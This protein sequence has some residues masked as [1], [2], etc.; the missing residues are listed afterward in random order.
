MAASHTIEKERN[1]SLDSQ[2]T[3]YSAAAEAELALDAGRAKRPNRPTVA[4]S[5][6]AAGA[7]LLG[8]LNADAAIQ[9]TSAN[10]TMS[11][12][13]VQTWMDIDGGGTDDIRFDFASWGA[14]RR[15]NVNGANGGEFLWVANVGVGDAV[16]FAY[17][18]TISSLAG[19]WK[20]G[21]GYIFQNSGTF[22]RGQF[23]DVNTG[24]LGVR[25]SAGGTKYGWI[26][27]DLVAAGGSSFHIAGYAYED[28]GSPIQA[29]ARI[30]EPSTIALALLASGAAGVM[31]SRRK[32]ILKGR[33]K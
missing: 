17:G 31:R 7:G 33:G 15:G 13:N 28:D 8:A 21:A 4:Y 24:Y 25:F 9:Y 14:G 29:G 10:L 12:G 2:L 18:A 32:K 30:P 16:R 5:A 1:D 20:G 6:A 19:T 23:S 27:I 26:H 3:A 11:T 22:S